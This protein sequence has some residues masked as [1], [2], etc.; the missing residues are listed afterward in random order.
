MTNRNISLLSVAMTVLLLVGGCVAQPPVENGEKDARLDLVVSQLDKSLANQAAA[1]AQLQAQQQQLESQGQNLAALNQN[2]GKVLNVPE[3]VEC[4]KAVACPSV[5]ES[6]TKMV[7]GGLEAVWFPDL[8]LEL[9]ARI[10]TGAETA[11]LDARDIQQFERDG[12][13]WVRFTIINPKTDTPETLERRLVRTVGIYQSGAA[14]AKRRPV[15]KLGVLIGQVEQT[16]EFS[17]SDR[18]HMGY[19]VMIGRSI[20]KDVMVVDVSRKNIA[21]YVRPDKKADAGGAA[22]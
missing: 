3:P 5:P 1:N 15:V 2:L 7:V 4:P 19:Q 14:E 9:T 17:L 11:S 12:K 22:Q 21:P 18:S 8:G 10:D 13:P 20:L 16:A 6:S